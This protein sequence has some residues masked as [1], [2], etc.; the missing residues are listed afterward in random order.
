VARERSGSGDGEDLV[1]HRRV[2]NERDDPHGPA[3]RRARE[4][5]DLDDLLEQHRRRA[6]AQRRVASVDTS[7]GAGTI[8][9]GTAAAVVAV[10]PR[11]PQGRLAD[12]P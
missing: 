5:V 2:G 7:R 3:T 12:Q 9:G 1:N 6:F 8:A 10:L 11:I 4:R